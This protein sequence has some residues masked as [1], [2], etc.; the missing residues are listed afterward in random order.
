MTVTPE[1][2]AAFHKAYDASL[3]MQPRETSQAIYDGLSAA[4][5]SQAQSGETVET[6]APQTNVLSADQLCRT[7]LIEWLVPTT[8]EWNAC[9]V[10]QDRY[11]LM[12][13]RIRLAFT[14]AALATTEGS[15][16]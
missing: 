2:I 3:E 15:A 1:M 5:A 6:P 9:E 4:L 12:K 16:E 13:R 7:P 10:M 11:D 8:E 14:D